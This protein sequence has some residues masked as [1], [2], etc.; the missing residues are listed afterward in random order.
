MA[1]REV[2]TQAK[3]I[4]KAAAKAIAAT[5]SA[6][7]TALLDKLKMQ[8]PTKFD[9]AVVE[10]FLNEM[11]LHGPP[12]TVLGALIRATCAMTRD[13]SVLVDVLET[14]SRN[15]FS[16]LEFDKENAH[17]LTGQ[18]VN[19]AR[20]RASYA[21][22]QKTF[23]LAASA[24]NGVAYRCRSG[25]LT[26]GA[27][28]TL[29]EKHSLSVIAPQE[30]SFLGRS[31]RVEPVL[32][33][34]DRDNSIQSFKCGY[35]DPDRNLHAYGIIAQDILRIPGA[36]AAR[37]AACLQ[38]WGLRAD[39]TDLIKQVDRMMKEGQTMMLVQ[40]STDR[41][42]LLKEFREYVPGAQEIEEDLKETATA[43]ASAP[44]VKAHGAGR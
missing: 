35:L 27:Y 8:L 15:E 22:L 28:A 29:A 44:R 10:R 34:S 43:T 24:G 2:E 33:F 13:S 41:G 16:W 19:W 25:Q 38:Q 12:E 4:S 23:A 11:A 20:W 30:I 17:M 1:A 6:G 18:P 40:G 5:A 37:V 3:A 31:E 36:P 9:K 14:V 32:L 42:A 26:R 39:V 21:L 7:W